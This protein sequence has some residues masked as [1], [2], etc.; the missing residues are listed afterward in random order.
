MAFGK[1]AAT[2]VIG[3]ALGSTY[4]STF[5][6]AEK[7][8]VKLGQ[9]YAKTNKKLAAVKDVVKYKSVLNQLKEKQE[10]TGGSSKQ[11]AAG[12][13][14][15]TQKYKKAKREAKGYGI[16]IGQIAAEQRKLARQAKFQGMGAKGL[17]Q[18]K[19]GKSVIKSTALSTFAEIGAIAL[20][21]KVAADFQREMST[22]KA[23]TGAVGSEFTEL[24]ANA[25]MLGR[26][27][28]FSAGEAAQ[29][30]SFLGQ[31]GFK[32]SEIIKT[33]PGLLNLA[34]AG[35]T[36]L[37]ETADISAGILKGFNLE[38]KDMTRVGDVLA[39]TFT[40][41]STDLRSLGEAMTY[42]APVAASLRISVE[43]TSA[44]M[45]ILGNAQITAAWRVPHSERC[46][47]VLAPLL[48]ME[49]RF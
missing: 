13:E 32:T 23:L 36:E 10:A 28:V 25:R 24:T 20:P 8:A 11:L 18:F 38:A 43:E 3:A 30:M 37:G 41:S 4:A 7:P 39:K 34:A 48:A 46:L 17:N 49:Q 14:T 22:V 2:I 35:G 44:V 45:G 15:V 40:S 6:K 1:T 16:Q 19:Q 31:K 47:P 29:G 9:A 5:V 26:T 42:V 21:V 12:I 27:T 33:M